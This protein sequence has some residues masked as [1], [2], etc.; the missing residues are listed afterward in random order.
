MADGKFA[1]LKMSIPRQRKAWFALL[2]AGKI[3]KKGRTIKMWS[4]GVKKAKTNRNKMENKD[5]RMKKLYDKNREEMKS[6][7]N[8]TQSNPND[9]GLKKRANVLWRRKE[10]IATQHR[11]K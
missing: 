2:S 8:K 5:T 6:N 4:K 1:P 9:L 11:G 7:W 3:D 10:I